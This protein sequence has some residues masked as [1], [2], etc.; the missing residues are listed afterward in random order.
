MIN[1]REPAEATGRPPHAISPVQHQREQD[2]PGYGTVEGH[3]VVGQEKVVRPL[4]MNRPLMRK[5]K[6]NEQIIKAEGVLC[7]PRRT[8]PVPGPG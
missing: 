1:H 8:P 2:T 6:G 7:R 4:A 5:Q 3:E